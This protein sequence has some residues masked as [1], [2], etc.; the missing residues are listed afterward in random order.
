MGILINMTVTFSVT[1]ILILILKEVFKN[2]FTP[3]WH[4]LIWTVLIIRLAIPILPESEISIFNYIP[5]MSAKYVHFID[6]KTEELN[7]TSVENISN[8]Q[9]HKLQDEN[10]TLK[11]DGSNQENSI[12]QT[13]DKNQ[14]KNINSMKYI[15][16][17]ILALYWLGT[18]VMAFA[19]FLSYGRLLKRIRK[20]RIC[21]DDEILEVFSICKEGLGVRSHKLT[22]KQGAESPMLAGVFKPSLYISEGYNNEELKHVFYHE[23]CHYKNKDNIWNMV[24]SVLLCMNWFNPLAWYAFKIFRRDLEMYCDYM[25][26]GIA[27]EKKAYA[28]VLLKTATTQNSFIFATTCLESGEKE[29]SQRIKKI[30]YFKTPKLWVSM[31]GL[32]LVVLLGIFCLTNAVDLSKK[33]QII[34]VNGPN[35][36]GDNYMM[37][38]PLSWGKEYEETVPEEPPYCEKIL[39]KDKKEN[40]VAGL[41]YRKVDLSESEWIPEDSNALTMRGRVDYE[42][43]V[44]QLIKQSSSFSEL[45][46]NHEKN[47]KIERIKSNS[48]DIWAAYKVNYLSNLKSVRTEIYLIA[49]DYAQIIP[50]LYKVSNRITD[51]ELIKVAMT[52]QK[53][54]EPSSYTPVAEAGMQTDTKAGTAVM[55]GEY[56]AKALMEDYFDNYVNI[57][58]PPSRDIKGYK[59]NSFE[60][61]SPVMDIPGIIDMGMVENETAPWNIIYP[62]A[63]VFKVDYEL[64][65]QDVKKYDD[66]ADGGYEITANGNKHYI[67]SYAVFYGYS[68]EG[69]TYKAVF[70]GF[71]PTDFLT[72]GGVDYSVL[73]LI[74]D[75]YE[76]EILPKV[77][78]NANVEYVGDASAVGKLV[79][80]LPLHEY[81]NGMELQTKVEPYGITANYKIGRSEPYDSE[82]GGLLS[83]WPKVDGDLTGIYS[84]SSPNEL[85]SYIKIQLEKNAK[86]LTLGIENSESTKIKCESPYLEKNFG[87]AY[88][89]PYAHNNSKKQ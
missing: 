22:L 68:E 80:L 35:N 83:A 24:S 84:H 70:L 10:I 86:Y 33:T 58:M 44:K 43:K 2:R 45:A 34:G 46:D 89:D 81:S 64:I 9:D 73:K 21:S 71:L 39:F 37:E 66:S 14:A 19:L 76:R 27:G 51:E 25:V 60:Q 13:I 12:A 48:T 15:E 50:V 30:A 57:V 23:L 6:Q 36:E 42:S 79:R 3:K 85:N 16:K 52:L 78:R 8:L 61:I 74:N 56:D 5:D 40:E 7:N 17:I 77:L 69:K 55:G 82:K 72:E 28:E 59:I 87:F 47:V 63:K 54:K 41:N 29:V 67:Q 4:V 53:I 31:V 75:K 1:V 26:I 62:T 49:D 88:S 38:V 32:L 18:L 65:P 11:T 20:L